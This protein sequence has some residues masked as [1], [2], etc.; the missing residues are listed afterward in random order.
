MMNPKASLEEF[1]RRGV[2]AQ[3]AA[4]R[5]LSLPFDAQGLTTRERMTALAC[6]FPELSRAATEPGSGIRPFAADKLNK[7]ARGGRGHG[8]QCAARFVLSVWNPHVRWSSGRF[9]VHE[10]LRVW[11]DAH[12]AAFVAWCEKAWWP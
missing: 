5:T 4:D 9:D 2:A 11:D 10:A 12:R 1:A 3:S 7:W 6:S 8:A